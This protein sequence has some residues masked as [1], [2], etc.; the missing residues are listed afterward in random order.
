MADSIPVDNE[1]LHQIVRVPREHVNVNNPESSSPTT[2]TPPPAHQGAD[3]AD[4]AMGA[5]S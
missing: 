4:A 5:I 2:P 3:A 1:M